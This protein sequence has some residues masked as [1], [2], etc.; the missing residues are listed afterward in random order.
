[1]SGVICGI[2]P[3]ISGGIAFLNTEGLAMWSDD[4][5]TYSEIAGG[6]SWLDGTAIGA[7]IQNMNPDVAVVERVSSRPGQGLSSTFR[8]G[9]AF[10]VCVGC[11]TALQ[12]PIHFIT[13]GKWKVQI[14][15]PA[16]PAYLTKSQ[17]ASFRKTVALDLAREL[18]PS[19]SAD[20]EWVKDHNRAEA[21][22][23]A[24]WGMKHG[25]GAI[26]DGAM[27]DVQRRR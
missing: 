27:Q 1:M 2:D 21:A 14:G 22:L 9:M 8:F 24:H 23:L 16:P 13:P 20:W 18:Y 26:Y 7:M 4:L 3:G 12:V 5:P 15:L 6:K 25:L 17:A 11:L 10:G 19:A